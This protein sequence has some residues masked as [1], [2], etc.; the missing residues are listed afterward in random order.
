ML[1]ALEVGLLQG[2]VDVE[3]RALAQR[4]LLGNRLRGVGAGAGARVGQAALGP[5][6][7][8]RA[9][10]AAAAAAP[11]AVAARGLCVPGIVKDRVSTTPFGLGGEM[12]VVLRAIPSPLPGAEAL[13]HGSRWR[14]ATRRRS[15]R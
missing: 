13:A 3:V 9:V 11:A 4:G 6:G 10:D 8:V 15:A 7:P 1:E 2:L 12:V 5:A 14:G